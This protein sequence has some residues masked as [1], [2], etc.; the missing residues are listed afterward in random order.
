MSQSRLYEDDEGYIIVY[1]DGC[2][3]NNGRG[4]AKAGIGVWFADNHQL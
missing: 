4:G 3:Y 1:T 2:C